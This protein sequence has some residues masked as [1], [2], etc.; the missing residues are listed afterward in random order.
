MSLTHRILVVEDEHVLAENVRTFLARRSP[1]VRV[2]GDGRRAMELIESFSPDVVVLDYGLPGEDGL[3]FYQEL[4]R[5]SARPIACVMI[6]GYPLETIAPLAK[7]LGIRHLLSK[8][9]R[10]C[11][12]QKLV[13]LS[14]AEASGYAHFSLPNMGE[15]SAGSPSKRLISQPARKSAKPD[16]PADDYRLRQQQPLR[17]RG[18]MFLSPGRRRL[19]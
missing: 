8:P 6:T 19:I 3:Q 15:T 12:L 5:H 9:F 17:Q 10:L 14:A 16:N 18:L 11:E 7:R 13:D 1:D 2:A 4:V